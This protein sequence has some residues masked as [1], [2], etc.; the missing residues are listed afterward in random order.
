[1]D[2]S[3]AELEAD[4]CARF[5]AMKNQRRPRRVFHGGLFTGQHELA[6]FQRH[7]QYANPE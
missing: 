4:A 7:K 5:E 3:A 6:L 1:M 2:G